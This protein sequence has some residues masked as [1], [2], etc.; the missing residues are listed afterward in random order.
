LLQ[1]HLVKNI[2]K[3]CKVVVPV[4]CMVP[5]LFIVPV[6]LLRKERLLFLAVP[7]LVLD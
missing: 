2:S 6:P 7:V 5:I 3:N 1:K 4:L